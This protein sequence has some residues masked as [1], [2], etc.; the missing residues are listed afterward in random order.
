MEIF[1][2]LRDE[3]AAFGKGEFFLFQPFINCLVRERWY[4]MEDLIDGSESVDGREE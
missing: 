3:P 4:F 1:K 2:W